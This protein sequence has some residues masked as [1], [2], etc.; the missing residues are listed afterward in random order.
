[1]LCFHEAG[2]LCVKRKRNRQKWENAAWPH[3]HVGCSNQAQQ[4]VYCVTQ[5]RSSQ[6]GGR[7]ESIG[8]CGGEMLSR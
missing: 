4:N 5:A 1:M 8:G 7:S 3:L 6:G 2:G